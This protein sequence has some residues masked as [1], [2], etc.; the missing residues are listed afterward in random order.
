MTSPH[1]FHMRQRPRRTRQSDA[2]RRLVC[3]SALTVSDLIWPIFVREGENAEEP[4]ASMPGVMRFSVDRAV[5]AAQAAADL[6]IPAVCIFPYTDPSL[7]TEACEE[8]WNPENISNRAIRAI[9]AA[10]PQMAVMTDIALDPYNINGHD[11]IV[12]G[13]KIVNDETVVAL[14]KMAL[15]QAEAGADILGPSDMM[16]GRIGAMRDALEAAGHQDVTIMSYSAKYASAYYGPFRDAVGAT[17]ALKGD[18]KTYQMDPGNSDE[19]LRMIAR[20][21]EEGADMVMVKPGQAYLDICHRV[22]S[23]FGVPT[24][25]YQVSGEYAMIEAAALNGW[26]DGEKIMME[27]L[28]GFKRAGCDGILT[29]FAPRV[30]RLLSA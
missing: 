11:G 23:E 28:L 4:V 9:K 2:I 27:S 13:G 19:A 1:A 20:D 14:V 26:I 16:D 6:G 30:A 15:A 7:K 18:K 10:V 12:K 8:A 5:A 21:L 22:K 3:E 24:F 29:Y 17:G 25:A